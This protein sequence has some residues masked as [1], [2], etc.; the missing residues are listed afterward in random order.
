M[1]PVLFILVDGDAGNLHDDGRIADGQPGP[2]I[3][4]GADRQGTGRRT[5][6]PIEILEIGFRTYFDHFAP[7]QVT[8]G[9]EACP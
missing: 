6:T 9:T 8:F 1:F 7:I 3:S 4:G 2:R 5:G